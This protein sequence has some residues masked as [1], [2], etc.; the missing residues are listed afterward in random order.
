VIACAFDLTILN[1]TNASSCKAGGEILFNSATKR[2]TND[3]NGNCQE[4]VASSLQV[5]SELLDHL[6]RIITNK[7][8]FA[9]CKEESV[10]MRT[11]LQLPA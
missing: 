4:L 2:T 11:V 3:S 1:K 8:N 10:T 7:P 9:A 6:H 5:V